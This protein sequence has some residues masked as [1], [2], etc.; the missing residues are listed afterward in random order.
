MPAAS[1]ESGPSKKRAFPAIRGIGK[2]E[3]DAKTAVF[4]A[5]R[6]F[7]RVFTVKADYFTFVKNL[8]LKAWP[9]ASRNVP[10]DASLASGG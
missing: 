5:C 1:L 4:C 3:V 8:V 7:P 6:S 10:P 2:S 9:E